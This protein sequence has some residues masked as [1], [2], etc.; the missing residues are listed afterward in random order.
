MCTC[1]CVCP[2]SAVCCVSAAQLT[3]VS[4]WTSLSSGGFSKYGCG[5]TAC[6]EISWGLLLPGL[7]V[8]GCVCAGCVSVGV[9]VCAACVWGLWPGCALIVTNQPLIS[10]KVPDNS[11]KQPLGLPVSCGLPVCVSWDVSR[12]LTS[13]ACLWVCPR[14]TRGVSAPAETP[15]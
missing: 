14:F 6:W 1:V 2:S 9:C 4:L 5:P 13:S 7:C 8:W 3:V 12:R 10:S 11:C 15:S